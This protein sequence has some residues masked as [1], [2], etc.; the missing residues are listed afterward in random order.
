MALWIKDTK[1]FKTSVV[2][3]ANWYDDESV[4]TNP[5]FIQ[6][7]VDGDP[8][9]YYLCYAD[10]EN[11]IAYACHQQPRQVFEWFAHGVTD[12]LRN[13][14]SMVLQYAVFGQIRYL[15]PTA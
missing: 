13:I 3:N 7:T 8:S 2:T 10:V 9:P 14:A 15:L 1:P 4:L 11:G 5:Y 12:N 6:I